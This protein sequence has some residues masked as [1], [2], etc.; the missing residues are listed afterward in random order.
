VSFDL[1]SEIVP[2]DDRIGV[3][4]APLVC[5]R[6]L[7]GASNGTCCIN[8]GQATRILEFEGRFREM[9]VQLTSSDVLYYGS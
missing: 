2:G 3:P 6:S 4:E 9:K 8:N 5:A 7:T 1:Q